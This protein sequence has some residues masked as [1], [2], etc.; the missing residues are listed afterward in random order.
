MDYLKELSVQLEGKI[1][2]QLYSN[3]NLGAGV[4][5]RQLL[6]KNYRQ[7]HVEINEFPNCYEINIK[8]YSTL[9][10]SINRHDIIF[11]LTQPNKLKDFPY[12][13]YTRE[14]GY[15]F[16][17]NGNFP[18][19]WNLFSA[20]L[21]IFQFKISEGVF[22]YTN[23]VTFAL[24]SKRDLVKALDKI[25]DFFI[26]NS[27]IFKKEVSPKRINPNNIPDNL[28]VLLP[29][30]KKYSVSDDSERSELIEQMSEKQ[31]TALKRT[32]EPLMS[33][34]EAYLD[35]LINKVFTHE[36]SL[37]SALA[38]LVAELRFN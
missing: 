4:S 12:I 28:K 11:L 35:S 5:T 6:I 15:V 13:V 29:L 30:L 7:F 23:E 3:A 36:D 34:I 33:E 22:F 26:E 16:P 19:F 32:V 25:I 31:K 17:E 37:I 14:Q 18:K 20:L 21:N 27:T 8:V 1:K 24:D 10:F 9:H 2:Q 38:E